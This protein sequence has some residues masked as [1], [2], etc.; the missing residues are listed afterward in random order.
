MTLTNFFIYSITEYIEENNHIG[1]LIKT[2]SII[3]MFSFLIAYKK[4]EWKSGVAACLSCQLFY[5]PFSM[6]E[7][8]ERA[9]NSFTEI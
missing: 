6:F 7:V 2:V 1:M 5:I 3:M 8:K 9:I 4:Y